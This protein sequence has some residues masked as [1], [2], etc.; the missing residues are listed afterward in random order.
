MVAGGRLAQ[1]SISLHEFLGDGF[2]KISIVTSALL[3][4]IS[5]FYVYALGSHL[6]IVVYYFLTRFTYIKPFSE[7]IT[8]R[9]FDSMIIGGFTLLWLALSLNGKF[10]K[11]FV[12]SIFGI[13]FTVAM[14]ANLTNLISVVELSTLPLVILILFCQRGARSLR[15]KKVVRNHQLNLTLNYLALIAIFLGIY[16]IAISL[17]VILASQEF[18]VEN[19]FT[20]K[21]IPVDNYGY[22]VFV[23]FSTLSPILLI[24]IFFGLPIK[25][26]GKAILQKIPRS[27]RK[28]WSQTTEL[29]SSDEPRKKRLR[30]TYL[31]L[32]SLLSVSLALIPQVSTVN[33]DNQQI[34]SDSDEYV[35]LINILY[36]TKDPQDFFKTV[37]FDLM[38]GDRP[39]SLIILYLFTV[40]VNTP[41]LDALEFAPVILGPALV[42][43]VYFFTR[44]LTGNET[45][46]LF[47]ASLTGLG[48]FQISTGIYAGFYANWIALIVGYL[49]LIF[50][51]KFLRTP[52]KRSGLIFFGLFLAMMFSHAYTWTV[53]TIVVIIFLVISIGIKLYPRKNTILLLLLVVSC[54]VIDVVKTMMVESF[55]ASG[56]IELTIS[57]AQ[58]TL[59]LKGLG[60][61]WDTLVV[62][63]QHHFGGIFS[64]FV[65]LSLVIYWL[66]RSNLRTDFNLF[67]M[68]FLTIGIPPLFLGDWIVQSRV[69][70]NIPFQIPAAIGM[71]YVSRQ[72]N[73]LKILLPIYVWLV[74]ISI[75]TVSN[76]YK[77]SPS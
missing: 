72:K 67:V 42:L 69:F 49:S 5:L 29:E 75:W 73:G 64:N 66:V 48:Y 26:L 35:Q 6:P 43:V 53:F 13:I 38:R 62:A 32:F 54:I 65:I 25:V 8:T 24:V 34:G 76:F 41:I 56:G 63:T 18:S 47:A 16:S 37:F 7:Y 60:S 59:E 2:S 23:L 11:I 17:S 58:R 51:F 33:K 36:Q 19:V 20:S 55:R 77:V 21:R 15:G 57:L 1:Y 10:T 14:T 70:Y 40:I 50:F 27:T 3:A 31:L 22:E 28:N 61:I 39:L 44:E 71:T 45:A 4:T 9:Y 74:A 12:T 68:V 52:G 30:V 46:S